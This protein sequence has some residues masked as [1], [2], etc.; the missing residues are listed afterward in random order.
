M[1]TCNTMIYIKST[2]K[3]TPIILNN[4]TKHY[5]IKINII[6]HFTYIIYYFVI[7][8]KF[9]FKYKQNLLFNFESLTYVI[10]KLK[11]I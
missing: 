2:H 1:C 3:Y 10:N 6:V 7:F 8:F 4:K 9:K 5:L 11:F